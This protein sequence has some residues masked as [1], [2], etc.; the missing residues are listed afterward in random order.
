MN[1]NFPKT[2]QFKADTAPAAV[3]VFAL[4]KAGINERNFAKLIHEHPKKVHEYSY[5]QTKLYRLVELIK[6]MGYNEVI[7]I[8]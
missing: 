8:Y 5:R 7:V 6:I 2:F 4:E 1:A 3:F